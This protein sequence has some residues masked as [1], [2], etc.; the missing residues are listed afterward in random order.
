VTR[1][2]GEEY[3]KRRE[4][5][6][7]ISENLCIVEGREGAPATSNTQLPTPNGAVRTEILCMVRGGLM[8]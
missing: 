8:V 4:I 1:W 5:F 3:V 2:D 7:G 6:Q